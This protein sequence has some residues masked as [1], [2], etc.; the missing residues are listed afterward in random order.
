MT[1]RP[2]GRE[3]YSKSEHMSWSARGTVR[4]ERRQELEEKARMALVGL[5]GPERAAALLANA[6]RYEQLWSDLRALRLRAGAD[7]FGAWLELLAAAIE[8]G[9]PLERTLRDMIAD[10]GPILLAD[11]RESAQRH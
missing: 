7:A 2:Q 1:S 10:H 5:F 11:S 4:G 6:Q 8:R 3:R 9:E